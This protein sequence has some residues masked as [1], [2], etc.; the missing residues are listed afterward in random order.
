[1]KTAPFKSTFALLDV[2][3]GR[4]ALEKRLAKAGKPLRVLVEMT[5]NYAHG[6]DDGTSIEFSCSVLSVKEYAR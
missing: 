3:Q 4:A 5:I 6:S 1:M 2:M